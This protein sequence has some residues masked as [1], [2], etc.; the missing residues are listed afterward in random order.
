MSRQGLNAHKLRDKKMCYEEDVINCFK[1]HQKN[2]GKRR[3]QKALEKEHIKVSLPNISRILRK[4]GLVAKSGRNKR[5]KRTKTKSEY[6][7]EY[8]VKNK[9]DAIDFLDI[10][11][12]DISEFKCKS[13]KIQVSGIID[14]A[15]RM[16]VGV[17]ID[18]EA[19]KEL[20]L[21]TIKDMYGRY[22]IPKIY[23]CDRGCQYTALK[24][25]ELLESKGVTISMSRPGSPN[26]NQPIESIWNTM[27]RELKDISHM[28]YV[29]AV[30]EIFKYI[31]YYNSERMHSSIG[32]MT[33]QEYKNSLF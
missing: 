29:D 13:N 22:G 14:V 4:N 20:V 6:I 32:Y 2:Y 27:K 26:D 30:N 1:K 16:L 21:N 15:T 24:T 18:K 17:S 8:I 5:W 12:A 10:V 19:K 3:I 7:K 33:P 9:T 23:H 11:C 28:A 31:V 25:K